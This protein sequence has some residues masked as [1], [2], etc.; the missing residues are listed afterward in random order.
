MEMAD[1]MTA[2]VSHPAIALPEYVLDRE[3]LK[4]TA[5]SFLGEDFPRLK[6]VLSIIENSGVKERF[7]VRPLTDILKR[8]G[9]KE[10]N[11]LYIEKSKELTTR[12]AKGAL[13]NAGVEASDIDLIITTSCTG[14]M[15]PSVC[16]HL[17]PEL[18][19]RRDTTRLPI[20]ELGCAAGAMS[21][22]RAREYLA[23]YPGR[24]VLLVATELCS[25]C[26][27]P[28][29]LSMQAIVG[30]LLFGDGA[31]AT[32][33]KGSESTGLR[34]DINGTYLFEDSWDYMGFDVR[35]SG[36]H[37]ILD[38]DVPGAVERQISPVMK[39]FLH[40]HNVTRADL[41]FFCFHPG[42]RKLMDKIEKTFELTNNEL[43]ASRECL[44]EVGNLSSASILVVMKNIFERHRPKNGDRG[45][46]AAFGPGFSAEM[47]LGTWVEG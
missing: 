5:R 20:T 30:G 1:K 40:R 33:I 44:S 13:E 19:F 26:F 2:I 4:D 27:Q 46:L 8:S 9:F 25:L 24:N 16:A 18:G 37:L 31:A 29:D 35:D 14:F 41:D 6:T 43:I 12:A 23:A 39:E 7:I 42:G 3:A 28:E 45:M 34:L 38:K 11:D 22:S 10:T 17:I 47:L 15:I 36:F 21:L 32:V